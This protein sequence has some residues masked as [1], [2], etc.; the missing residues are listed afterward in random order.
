MRL[1]ELGYKFNGEKDATENQE[2]DDVISLE[3]LTIKKMNEITDK[4][5]IKKQVLCRIQVNE[6][7]DQD[8]WWYNRCIVCQEEVTKIDE[9]FKCTTCPRVM[10]IPQKDCPGYPDS[11]NNIVGKE[12]TLN[13]EINEDNIFNDSSI[14]YAIDVCDFKVADEISNS[15][16]Y[17]NQCQSASFDQTSEFVPG[18]TTLGTGKSSNKTRL[19]TYKDDS[20][21]DEVKKT[22]LNKKIK[23]E[24]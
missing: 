17:H 19:I 23:Q 15:D 4:T 24:K 22:L 7:E 13:I 1:E 21:F 5:Y 14:Y 20:E 12:Y 10:P 2:E 8:S 3:M 18:T 16:V 6:I 11:I 9:K